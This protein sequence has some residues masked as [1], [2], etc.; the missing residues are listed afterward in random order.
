MRC[1]FRSNYLPCYLSTPLP[2]LPI[3][4]S[5]LSDLCYLSLNRFIC[6]RI[7]LSVYFTYLFFLCIL[8]IYLSIYQSTD[9][10]IYVP[11]LYVFCYASTVPVYL[12]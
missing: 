5:Y 10:L 8:P 4:L 1:V 12:I 11:F 9:Q 7:Y 3:Y 6:L 2:I